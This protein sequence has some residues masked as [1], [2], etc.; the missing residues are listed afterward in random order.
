VGYFVLKRF[1]AL[2]VF[3]FKML[4]SVRRLVELQFEGRFVRE[5]GYRYQG[6]AS[7]GSNKKGRWYARRGD[8]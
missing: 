2:G 3:P 6:N 7:A 8:R 5:L 1:G 4:D